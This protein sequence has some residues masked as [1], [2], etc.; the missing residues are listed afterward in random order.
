[1]ND[2]LAPARSLDSARLLLPGADADGAQLALA[3]RLELRLGLWLLLRSAR[4]NGGHDRHDR[5]RRALNARSLNDR[6]HDALRAHALHIV[7]T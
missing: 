5:A 6:R 3:S 1:M 7:R 4:R 2:T